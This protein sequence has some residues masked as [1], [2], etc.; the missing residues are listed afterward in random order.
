MFLEKFGRIHRKTLVPESFSCRRPAT[1]LKKRRWHRCFPVNFAKFLRTSFRIEHLL[2]LLL[3]IE[4]FA[5]IVNGW[6]PLTISTKGY[7]LNI[8]QDFE[9]ASV[10]SG[11]PAGIYPLNFNNRNTRTRREIC[12]KLTIKT[13]ERHQWLYC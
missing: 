6:R 9:Y 12:S 2:W 8:W 1:L 13:P 10:F 4:L 5:N 3:K 11:N 7:I